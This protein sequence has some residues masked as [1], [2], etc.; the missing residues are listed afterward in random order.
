MNTKECGVSRRASYYCNWRYRSNYDDRNRYESMG[1]YS[2]FSSFGVV[3][4]AFVNLCEE[5][6]LAFEP[7]RLV[8][9]R[10]ALCR[11]STYSISQGMI[12]YAIKM[13]VV[14]ILRGAL[15]TSDLMRGLH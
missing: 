12:A 2:D 1:T 5:F 13:I 7:V 3:C 10:R 11:K 6:R 8:A 14:A 4:D 9:H 15:S